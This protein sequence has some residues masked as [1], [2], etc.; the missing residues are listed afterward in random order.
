MLWRFIKQYIHNSYSVYICAKHLLL[1]KV[2]LKVKM[3][4]GVLNDCQLVF[5]LIADT[6]NMRDSGETTY[7]N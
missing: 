3:I 1:A 6:Q 7:L 2:A 4:E 5:Y